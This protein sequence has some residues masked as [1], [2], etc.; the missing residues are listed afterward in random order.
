MNKFTNFINNRYN[1]TNTYQEN[2]IVQS[3]PKEP[4]FTLLSDATTV[5]MALLITFYL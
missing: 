4:I 2:V 1:I 3:Y 5:V